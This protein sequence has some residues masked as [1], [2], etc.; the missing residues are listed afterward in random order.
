MRCRLRFEPLFIFKPTMH[1]SR[2]VVASPMAVL[3]HSARA[4]RCGRWDG[5]CQAGSGLCVSSSLQPLLPA[6]PC[7]TR[8][9][10]VQRRLRTCELGW[11]PSDAVRCGLHG[12]LACSVLDLSTVH[13]AAPRSLHCTCPS[14]TQ[15]STLLFVSRRQR[16][17]QSYFDI[18]RAAVGVAA[19]CSPPGCMLPSDE[20]TASDTRLALTRRS[21]QPNSAR[22]LSVAPSGSCR[23]H[24]RLHLDQLAQPV[25][26]CAPTLLQ[27]PSS[28]SLPYPLSLFHRRR[29]RA[30]G[31]WQV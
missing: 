25:P 26:Q 20:S 7:R 15:H 28:L 11:A 9:R 23:P 22:S 24:L 10:T 18:K 21:P 5:L 12:R 13:F 17:L 19:R 14:R 4:M 1:A 29:S 3:R 2:S 31:V 27:L 8:P 16:L 30:V 6:Q